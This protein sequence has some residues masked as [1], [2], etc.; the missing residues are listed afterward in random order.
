MIV[1][2]VEGVDRVRV[3]RH[4]RHILVHED[5][6]VGPCR[7]DGGT[8][9]IHGIA[10]EVAAR[11]RPRDGNPRGGH[12][13]GL[14]A[15]GAGGCVGRGGGTGIK[16]GAHR[17]P[18][19]GGGK[20]G[21]AV[22]AAFGARR[23]VLFVGGSVRCLGTTR[24]RYALAASGR[25]RAGRAAGHQGCEHELTRTHGRG[26]A[27]VDGGSQIARRGDLVQRAGESDARIVGDG[28]LQ[29]RGGGDGRGNRH[30]AGRRL[31]V[32]AVVEDDVTRIVL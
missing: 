27:A 21:R 20:G 17:E 3:G 1:P 23:D 15:G 13:G 11:R 22:L 32:L 16:D 6:G 30:P 14:E 24:V 2:A 28:S 26:R 18:V 5:R 29:V 7:P 4:W 19:G 25:H 12:A 10:G 8:V 9:A 31:A